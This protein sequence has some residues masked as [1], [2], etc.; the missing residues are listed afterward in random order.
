MTNL[1]LNAT[2]IVTLLHKIMQNETLDDPRIINILKNHNCIYLLKKIHTTQTNLDKEKSIISIIETNEKYKQGRPIFNA[3][4]KHKYA[5]IKGATLSQ[6]VY[7]S[8]YMRKSNDLDIL[9][10]KEDV[11]ILKEILT[12]NGFIQGKIINNKIESFSRKE[13]IFQA[14]Q[15]H[16][17]APFIKMTGNKLCPYITYDVNFSPFWGEYSDNYDMTFVLEETEQTSLIGVQ[18]KKLKPEMEFVSLCLHHYKD[19]NSIYLLHKNSGINLNLFCDI[20]YYIKNVKLDTDKLFD[21]SERLKA[22]QYIY[23]CLWHTYKLFQG[24]FLEPLIEKFE[25]A[26]GRRLLTTFGLVE[27]ERHTWNIDFFDRIFS[28]DFME[29]YLPLLSQQDLEKIKINSQLM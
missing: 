7:G 25:T 12:R 13:L 27:S 21:I 4:N 16:Q 28:A 18:Y 17:I 26:E 6:Q 9:I 8:P 10:H 20:F 11:G 5:I 19:M 14:S 24:E 23:Y 1:Q 29:R 15:S 3:L 22:K 2:H